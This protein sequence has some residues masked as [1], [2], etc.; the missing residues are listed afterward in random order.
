MEILLQILQL[1]SALWKSDRKSLYYNIA[2]FF[3]SIF[4]RSFN[5]KHLLNYSIVE[6]TFRS[7]SN[8]LEHL[9]QSFFFYLLPTPERYISIGSY[10]PPVL[11]LA[12][13][14]ML[15]ISFLSLFICLKSLKLYRSL[16]FAFKLLLRIMGKNRR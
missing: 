12:V 6:S 13:G 14:L 15:H 1:R 2:A 11:L 3:K 4:V 10:L 9:H 7:L 16:I 5:F 8:L